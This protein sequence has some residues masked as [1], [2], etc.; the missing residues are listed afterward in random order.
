LTDPS[1]E[2]RYE[3]RPRACTRGRI[4]RLAAGMASADDDH[5]VVHYRPWAVRFGAAPGL[6]RPGVAAAKST[7]RR[8]MRPNEPECRIAFIVS[9]S[10]QGVGF[11]WWTVRQ[12]RYLGLRGTV[13]NL[14]DGTVEVQAAGLPEAL[15]RFEVALSCGPPGARVDRLTTTTQIRELPPDFRAVP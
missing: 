9:G 5:I 11:R 7:G 10:V 12:A 13:R 4:P 1:E 14:A 3:Q 2:R 15:A 8:R 6:G